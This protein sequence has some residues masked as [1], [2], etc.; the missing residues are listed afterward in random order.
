MEKNKLPIV[1]VILTC[2]CILS[3]ATIYNQCQIKQEEKV[4]PTIE[5]EI[6]EGPISSGNGS[7]C[8]YRIKAIVT[9]NPTPAIEFSKDDSSGAWGEYIAQVNLY[10]PS[11]I[12]TLTATATNSEGSATDSIEIIWGFDEDEKETEEVIEAETILDDEETEEEEKTYEEAPTIKLEVYQGPMYSSSSNVCYYRVRASVTGIPTPYVEFLKD[13]SGGSLGK[14]NTQVNLNSPSD[15][16]TLIATATNSEG[17]ASNSI[18]LSWGCVD[19]KDLETNIINLINNIRA[20]NGLNQLSK[21]QSLTDIARMR[22]SDMIYNSYF[23]HYAP[24]GR[25]IF[26]ILKDNGVS[27]VNA[28]ENL[29]VATNPALAGTAEAFVNAWMA[30]PSHRDNILRPVYRYIGVGIIEEENRRIVTSIFLN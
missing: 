29:G 18:S 17:S 15:T 10:D 27:Y 23:S 16:Y 26:N 9:G 25:N 13:D 5:L 11:E 12:C 7:I 19:L 20:Q 28:G 14:Y 3:T 24:D 22:S 30:S 21:S 2:I 4:E 1:F 6:Y 8:Y